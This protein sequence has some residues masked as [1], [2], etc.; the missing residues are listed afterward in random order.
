MTAAA[1]GASARATT[2]CWCACASCAARPGAPTASSAQVWL[3]GDHLCAPALA[4]G[5]PLRRRWSAESAWAAAG[6]ARPG[7]SGRRACA[8]RA[9]R[10]VRRASA[11]WSRRR[12]IGF[13]DRAAAGRRTARRRAHAWCSTGC[14][15]P[16]TSA[17]SCAARRRFGVRAGGGAQGHGGAVVAQ[18]AARRHGRALR[19]APG[20][21]PASR[22]TCDALALP[23]RGHQLARAAALLHRCALPRPCAWVFGHEGQGVSPALL[24]RCALTLRIPQPGG[25]ESLNVAAAAAVCLYESCAS[26]SRSVDQPVRAGCRAGWWWRSPRSTCA[27]TTARRC[28]RGASSPRPRAPRSGSSPARRTCCRAGARCGSAPG[29][30]GRSSGRST[31]VLCGASAGG[32]LP[33]SKSSGISG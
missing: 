9:R 12:R 5:R 3:E 16:A 1:A 7:R 31:C 32:S 26:A 25:E 8:L 2:R 21:G 18:G 22:A 4:R 29:A 6:A 13:A 27:S 33:R 28:P 10:A 24:A 11:R 19:A 30:P 15:T 14:R 20:R 17:A 23:L